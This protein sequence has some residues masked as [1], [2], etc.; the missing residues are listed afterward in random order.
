MTADSHSASPPASG[1]E[2]ISNSNA[3]AAATGSTAPPTPAV[4][5]ET[6]SD[7]ETQA[8]GQIAS[9]AAAE[10]LKPRIKIGTQRPGVP[11]PRIEPRAKVAFRTEPTQRKPVDRPPPHEQYPAKPGA[12]KPV[13]AKTAEG[14]SAALAADEVSAP[15]AP[16]RK[17][18]PNVSKYV[19]PAPTSEKV[20]RPNIRAELS[21]ELEAELEA[22]LGDQS[23]D[24]LIAAETGGDAGAAGEPLEVESRHTAQVARIFRDN[25]FVDLSGRNQGVLTLHILAQEPQVGDALEVV[26]TRFNADD[27]LYE[28]A[29]IGASVQV[30]DWTD[31]AE[32]ITVEARVTG[33]NKGGLECE[34]NKIRGFIPAGQISI[35]RVE[36]FEEFV[37]QSWACV[38]IEANQERRNLVLSRRAVLEREQAEAKEQ[39]LTQLKVGDVREG[40]V[41]NIRDFGAFVDLG[42]IDGMVHVSQMSWDRVKHPSEVLTV[43]QKVQVK[44]QKIDP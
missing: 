3:Q 42:G 7:A 2:E 20:E 24:E 8:G 11:V 38:V 14:E 17:A 19:S 37:G 21:P 32:G 28:V 18:A 26:V 41:R 39:L 9:E 29:P 25:V 10:E 44:I 43:G 15:P 30:G 4:L 35:Y 31:I 12:A 13:G 33:H 23:M 5:P 6:A 40:V 22:A 27:G 1:A 36:N 16:Q 34:V